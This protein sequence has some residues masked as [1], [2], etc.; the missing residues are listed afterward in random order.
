MKKRRN[1]YFIFC[2]IFIFNIF[3]F[4]GCNKIDN[5]TV[6]NG[7]ETNK[8]LYI[9]YIDVGQAD[10]IFI[11]TPNGKNMLIDAGETK[12]GAIKNYLNNLNVKKIDVL[13]AT[14]PH[15]DHISEM[16]DIINSYEVESMYM[17]KVSHTTKTFEN[18]IDA[19]SS[20]G[21]KVKA[22]KAGE[23]IDIDKDVICNI[24]APSKDNYDNLNNW[25]AVI[26]LSYGQNSFLFTGDAETLS[27]EEILKNNTNIKSD[28]LKVGH[29]G[30]STSTSDKFLE[31]I[32]PTYAV[33]SAGKDNDYGH[34]HKEIVEK[35]SNIKTFITYEYGTVIAVSDG[36]NITIESNKVNSDQ[37]SDEINSDF[38]G[39]VNSKKFHKS[40]CSSL[41][42]EKNRII[43]SSKNEAIKQGYSPCGVCKP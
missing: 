29:H 21:L 13:V 19:A 42:S 33:I 2:I 31:A 39:N 15:S 25:S 35:L 4:S 28:I 22:A 20:K 24:V 43:F 27:E 18:M 12:D 9:H 41:P 1:L 17:P 37:K 11:Q 10:S 34:P 32:N 36:K 23:T 7:A 30:S 5:S 16:A 40:E 8:K 38:I 3:I 6:V 26:H 14:H